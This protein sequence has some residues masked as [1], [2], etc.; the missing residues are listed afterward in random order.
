MHVGK[1]RPQR[2]AVHG[3]NIPPLEMLPNRGY[4]CDKTDKTSKSKRIII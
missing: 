4:M 2:M 3:A 1:L